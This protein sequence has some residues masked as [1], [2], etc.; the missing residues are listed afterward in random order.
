MAFSFSYSARWAF[1]EEI[2][3]A[4]RLSSVAGAREKK[5][6]LQTAEIQSEVIYR[7]KI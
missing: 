5:K 3:E 1:S 6:K 4:P 2:E 7:K